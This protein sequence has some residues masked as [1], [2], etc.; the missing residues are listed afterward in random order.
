MKKLFS[1]TAIALALSAGAAFAADLPAVRAPLPPPPPPPLLWTGFYAGLNAG[2][3]WGASNYA[4]V[5]TAT[6]SDQLFPGFADPSGGAGGLALSGITN[7]NNR[8]GFLGGAQIGYNFQFG[9]SFLV[10]I[11][12]DIQGAAIRGEGSVFGASSWNTFNTDFLDI[13]FNRSSVGATTVTARTDWLGTVRGR[14]G[15]L[16]N[17]SL[18]IYATGGLAYG[19]AQ[20]TVHQSL[21]VNNTLSAF[22]NALSLNVPSASLGGVGRYDQARVGWTVGGGL[23]WLF[24]PNLSLKAEYLYYD[25]GTAHFLNSP[26]VAAGPSVGIGDLDLGFLNSVHQGATRVKFDGHIARIGL[27]YHFNTPAPVVPVIAKY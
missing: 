16:W 3:S 26:V 27:N 24:T 13:E 4:E 6:I 7:L 15:W 2:Y 12:T 17:Q 19:G 22:D 20:A 5:G 9:N 25:L 14:L 10:G 1:A 21:L 23:E 8:G 18:L 11:E